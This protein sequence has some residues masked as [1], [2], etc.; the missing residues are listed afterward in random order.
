MFVFQCILVDGQE[1]E[2]G[3]RKQQQQ[4]KTIDRTIKRSKK[5]D[6]NMCSAVS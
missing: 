3:K 2:K 4:K 1:S 6:N 5:G